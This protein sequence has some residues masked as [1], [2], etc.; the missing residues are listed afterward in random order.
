MTKYLISKLKAHK[1][2]TEEQ[3]KEYGFTNNIPRFYYMF[4]I[5]SDQRCNNG[6]YLSESIN[7]TFEKINNYIKL[8]SIIFLYEKDILQVKEYKDYFEG[9][10]DYSMLDDYIK[11]GVDVA[12]KLLQDLIDKKILVLEK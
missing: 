3:L 10:V 9:K 4:K 7:I 2:L 8:D 1:G 6:N 12:E 5:I 11:K